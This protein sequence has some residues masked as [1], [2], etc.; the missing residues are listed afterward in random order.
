MGHPVSI[1][2]PNWPLL[3]D[4]LP[5]FIPQLFRHTFSKY[6]AMKESHKFENCLGLPLFVLNS[7]PFHVQDHD[8]GGGVFRPAEPRLERVRPPAGEQVRGG[9][10]HHLG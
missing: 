4:F 7:I 5:T 10:S 9:G 6:E 8:D 3:Q 2:C 1:F